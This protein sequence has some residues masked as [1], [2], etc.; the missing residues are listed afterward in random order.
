MDNLR[1][2]APRLFNHYDRNAQKAK[3]E[4]KESAKKLHEQRMK[5]ASKA[6]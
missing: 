3:Y 1:V 4:L 6:S 5:K 2:N